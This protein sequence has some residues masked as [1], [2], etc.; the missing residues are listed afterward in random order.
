M[1]PFF[2]KLDD[3]RAI[4]ALERIA[5]ALELLAKTSRMEPPV[6]DESAVMY[7]N[8]RDEA[9]KEERKEAYYQRTGIRL[10]EEDDV[11]RP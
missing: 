10:S 3:L 6:R 11:P 2:D 1:K 7:V 8:D 5:A 4:S 9:A